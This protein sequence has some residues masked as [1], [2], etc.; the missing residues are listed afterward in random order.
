VANPLKNNY[1]N[2]NTHAHGSVHL[3]V[4]AIYKGEVVGVEL[5]QLGE[6]RKAFWCTPNVVMVLGL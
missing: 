2:T 1:E 4:L 6:E 3:V 5:D